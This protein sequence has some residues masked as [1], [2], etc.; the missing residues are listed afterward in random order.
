MAWLDVFLPAVSVVAVFAARVFELGTRRDTVPG[1]VKENLTLRLFVLTGVIMLISVLGELWLPKRRISWPAFVLGWLM[2]VASFGIRR[3]AI[4]ALGQFWSLHVEIRDNHQF[5]RTGPFRWLRHPTYFSM[6]LELASVAVITTSFWSLLIIPAVFFPILLF[7]L[8]IEESA[9]VEKF[10]AKYVE[11]Q[12]TTPAIF[13][14]K[15]PA[16]LTS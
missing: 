16:K 7:R 4:A 14:C 9:L 12:R 13:P 1:T 11:Y 15:F 6:I 10:G 2:A 3:R 5:V 8:R